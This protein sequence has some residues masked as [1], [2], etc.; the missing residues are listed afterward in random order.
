MLR[1]GFNYGGW[2][3]GIVWRIWSSSEIVISEFFF[4][5]FLGCISRDQTVWVNFYSDRLLETLV[6]YIEACSS[7]PCPSDL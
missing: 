3:G 5:S 7:F 4:Q 6:L 2:M 1:G